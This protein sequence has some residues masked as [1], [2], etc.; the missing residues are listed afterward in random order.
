MTLL[1]YLEGLYNRTFGFDLIEYL[2]GLEETSKW[3]TK[4]KLRQLVRE[5][6][7]RRFDNGKLNKLN[8]NSLIYNGDKLKIGKFTYIKVSII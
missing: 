6:G 1:D 4:N 3:S 2:Y 5:G 8:E 7:V